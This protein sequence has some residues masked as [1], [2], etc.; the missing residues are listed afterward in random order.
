[1]IYKIEKK[2]GAIIVNWNSF[3]H[4]QTCIASI[5]AQT[6][7]FH[8]VV[9]VDNASENQPDKLTIPCPN[10][11]DFVRLPYNAGFA[12]ANNIAIDMLDDCDWVALVNPD[13]FLEPD[14]LANLLEAAERNPDFSFFASQMVMAL[15]STRLDGAGDVY[16]ISGLVWRSGHGIKK[17]EYPLIEGEVFSPCAAAA[18]YRRDILMNVG[19]F[20]EEFFCYVEDVDL[21]FRLRLAGYRCLLVPDAVANHVGSVTSG[22]QHSDFAVYHGHRNLIWAF[23]KNM[24]GAL[25]WLMLPPFIMMNIVTFIWFILHGQGRVILRAKIDAIIGTPKMWSKRK[26]IQA[27]RLASIF[28]IWRILDK[29][30][31][32][33]R[34]MKNIHNK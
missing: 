12:K 17:D 31:F 21:A 29:R 19:A 4:L 27:S 1:M 5:T 8:R 33:N 20:D 7:E 14:W 11:T 13:A 3:E 18:L 6:I 28:D 26:K 10:N 2:V 22:G 24:P 16:H 15:D 30:L 23:M 32:L 25:L 9:V 34:R